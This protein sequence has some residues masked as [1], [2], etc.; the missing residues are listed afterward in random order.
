MDSLSKVNL[1]ERFGESQLEAVKN[2]SEV[3]A[4]EIHRSVCFFRPLTVREAIAGR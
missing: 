1:V 2:T 3:R 4:S